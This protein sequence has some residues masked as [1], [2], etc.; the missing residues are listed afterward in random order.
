MR[1]GCPWRDLPAAFGKFQTVYKYFNRL[2][3]QG[4]FQ[5]FFKKLS[6]DADKK[7]LMMDDSYI[8]AH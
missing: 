4:I 2:S 7:W 6:A 1:T 3:K 8:R 5:R